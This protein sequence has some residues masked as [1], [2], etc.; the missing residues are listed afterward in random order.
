[1]EHQEGLPLRTILAITIA[2]LASSCGTAWAAKKPKPAYQDAVLKDFRTEQKGSECSTRGN[3]DG[4]VTASTSGG[5]TQGTV[6]ANSRSNTSCV[7]RIVAFYTVVM[8]DHTFVLSPSWSG[9]A[10]IFHPRNSALYGVLPGTPVKVKSEDGAIY[11]K[12]DDR[13]SEYTIVSMK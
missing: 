3:T 13:E 2:L 1:M 9:F 6:D 7:P 4:T 12:V 10:A 5:Y 8:G 11:V